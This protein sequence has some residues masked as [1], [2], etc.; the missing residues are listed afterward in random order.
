[1]I[2]ESDLSPPFKSAVACRPPWNL[3][4]SRVGWL[5][6]LALVYCRPLTHA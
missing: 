5:P 4:L 3:P 1:M 6:P 2:N